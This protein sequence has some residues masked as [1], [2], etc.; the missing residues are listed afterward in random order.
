MNDELDL[1]TIFNEQKKLDIE[2]HKNHKVSYKQVYDRLKLALVVELSEFANEIR[3]FKFW[4]YKRNLDH[5]KA[6]EEYVDGIHF[7]TSLCIASNVKPEDIKLP[8]SCNKAKY[9]TNEQNEI[10]ISNL[11]LDLFN[12]IKK[13]DNNKHLINWYKKYLNLGYVL[14]ISNNEILKSY[15][16]KL[17]VNHNR[18]KEKY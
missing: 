4:S 7:I 11:F 15:L 18:Q 9:I 13:L 10:K 12:G 3:C 17:K 5:N 8:N 6:L 1:K 16:N 2:I 14:N